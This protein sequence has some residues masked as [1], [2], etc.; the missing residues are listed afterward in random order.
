MDL[1]HAIDAVQRDYP[2]VW[3]AAH[4]RHP[5]RGLGGDAPTER[6][7]TVL[8][9]LDHGTPRRIADLA[10]HL[11]IA[12]STLSEVI[13]ALEARGWVARD[14]APADGRRVLVTL[15]DAGRARIRE[16]SPLDADR[17]RA[18]LGRL[19]DAERALVVRGLHTLAE[20]LR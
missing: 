5:P 10:D 11:A 15:T 7:Q 17:L 16:A 8:A 12:P 19:D 1:E 13:G 3:H 18:A 20:A 9:H 4:R 14:R 6:E 2:R